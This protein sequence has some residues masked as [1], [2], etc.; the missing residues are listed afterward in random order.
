MRYPINPHVVQACRR[1]SQLIA[2]AAVLLGGLVLAGWAFDLDLLKR[3]LLPEPPMM[4]SAATCFVLAGV[5]LWLWNAKRWPVL[6]RAFGLLLVCYAGLALIEYLFRVDLGVDRWLFGRALA[7][8]DVPFTGRLTPPGAI[9]LTLIGLA[10][11]WLEA[12]TKRR[13][14]RPAE[15][16]CLLAMIYPVVLLWG[17]VY[18]VATFGSLV[19][20]RE[21]GTG[22]AVTIIVLALGVLLARPER[23]MMGVFTS[24]TEA[25]LTLR[26][27][28]PTLLMIPLAI[29]A[30]REVAVRLLVLS[31]YVEWVLWIAL[32]SLFGLLAILWN[33]HSL[34]RMAEAR[35]Q[36]ESHRALLA[37]LVEASHDAILGATKA[38]TVSSMNEGAERLFGYASSDILGKPLSL[39]Y[40]PE[41]LVEYQENTRRIEKGECVGPYDSQR[42]HRDGRR[43]DVSVTLSPLLTP[44]GQ[45]SGYVAVLR[46]I[47][48]RKHLEADLRRARDQLEARVQER[49]AELTRVNAALRQEITERELA[50]TALQQA[51]AEIFD[52]YNHAPCGYHSL[53]KDGRIV[54]INETELAW[55]GYA[56]EEVLGKRLIY[57][58]LTPQSAEKVRRTLPRF[59]KTG[60][61]QNLEVDMVRKDGT[62]MSVL[63]SASALKDADGNYLVS[64]S[65][66]FDIT[67]RKRL[68][69]ELRHS[70]A[71]LTNA[72]RIAHVGNWELDLKTNTLRWSDEIYRIFGLQPQEFAATYEAFLERVH[73]DDRAS[74]KH[75]VD[76]ALFCQTPYS[77]EHRIVRPD[78][79]E[80]IVQEQ[81]DVIY[82]EQK[83][84]IQML[85][86]VQDITDVKRI[87]AAIAQ[88][89]AELRQAREI[90]RLKSSFVNAVSHDLRA[91][92]MAILG[93]AEL[94]E[95]EV[96]GPLVPKQ[97]DFVIQ[98]EKG[99]KRLE[100]MVNDLLDFARMEAGTFA[101]NLSEE[102][103]RSKIGDV[104]ESLKP[105]IE[106]AKV[107]MVLSLPDEPLMA[108]MDGPRTERVV[109]NLLTNALKFTPPGG[110][111]TVRARK[112]GTYL[113][114][115]V[116]DTGIGIA[117]ED[118]PK[119]FQ[120]FSQLEA[121]RRRG[122]TGLGLSI[123][124]TFVEAQGGKIGVLSELG[125]GSTF[126]FMLPLEPSLLPAAARNT[127]RP[128]GAPV[129]TRSASS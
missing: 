5:S 119:L 25:G 117:P 99:T 71:S 53:D 28:I 38:W 10:L 94:L 84:P 107:E 48:V 77:I 74:V 62:V 103:L 22:G 23:G 61:I 123:S 63:L 102:D 82:D 85:G 95:D 128:S 73:P 106:E 36:A 41:R 3:A 72:Q 46:D 88:R 60:F 59:M 30:I 17:Y 49:T 78:G 90:E 126:W 34:T 55:L 92:I 114:C 11:F 7:T 27:T 86:V 32:A 115:E 112:E 58:L 105:L 2:L 93:Y 122:G 109:A 75:A 87:Q 37:S 129:P 70:E 39:F 81:A 124:K 16:M 121:G 8:L 24:D 91:P 79:T 96:A 113:L 45:V 100:L 26:R 118:L 6:P 97:R 51:A 1:V 83:Q 44:T 125:K 52:L 21:L 116:V 20:V 64:R 12:D 29:G 104:V 18:H 65:T 69:T 40:P 42:L 127:E 111:I 110:K 68:E 9:G 15:F 89:D 33:V 66:V 19:G 13:G 67:E 50:Q 54:R 14:L 101:L 4:P 31:P 98:I 43:I 108:R 57:D 56:S 120:R 47:T 76:E 80:R 35:E